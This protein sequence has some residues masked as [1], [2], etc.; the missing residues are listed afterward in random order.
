LVIG[1]ALSYS[2]E[3][4][5]IKYMSTKEA[6]KHFLPS[7]AQVS[8]VSKTLPAGKLAALKKKYDLNDSTDF[9]NTL[10][11][12]P[13]TVYIGRGKDG[14]AQIYIFIMEQYWRTCY[15]KF[16]VGVT[17]DGSIKELK[18]M[19]FPCKYERPIA[20]KSFLKQFTGKKVKGGKVPAKLKQD[21][22][23]VTGAT[24]SSN[25]ATIVVRRA[26]ALHEAF[27]K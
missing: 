12:G 24:A 13:H 23:V 17:P 27:F 10:T 9:K 22:D 26:L 2:G 5:A 19:D 15:H 7:G 8:K 21:I 4:A 20:K 1:F 18:P 6:I 25:V 11:A 3:A 14:K 16:V